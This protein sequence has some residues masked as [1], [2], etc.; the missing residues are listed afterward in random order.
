MKRRL[1]DLPKWKF[2]R[3]PGKTHPDKKMPAN[4]GNLKV[5]Y[6]CVTKKL[7]IMQRDIVH[8]WFYRHPPEKVWDFLTR[9]ELLATWLMES[10]ISPEVG[11]Q[12]R[13]KTK[14]R[15]GVNPSSWKSRTTAHRWPSSSSKP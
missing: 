9:P 4:I 15:P 13:F 2:L 11:R 12:F 10:D 1:P 14:S 6:I 7:L 8:E 5:T 3:D